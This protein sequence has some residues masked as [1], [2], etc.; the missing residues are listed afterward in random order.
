M[1]QIRTEIGGEIRYL[2]LNGNNTVDFELSFAE[3]QDLT[4]KNSVY[5][6]SFNLPGSK[7]NADIFN[8]FFDINA[9]MTDYDVRRKFNAQVL[10]NGYELLEGYI[11]LESVSVFPVGHEY[12]ITFYGLIGSLAS[13][14]G[15]KYLSA[16]DLSSLT[17]PYN[18]TVV[19]FGSFYDPDIVIP[20]GT[21]E[22]YQD[23]RVWWTLLSRGYEYDNL[24]TT[25]QTPEYLLTPVLDFSNGLEYGYMD[26]IGTPVRY[27]YFVPSIQIR[28]LYT[29]IV[30]QA[31]FGIK[32]D[33][34]DTAYFKRFYLPQTFF[35]SLYLGQSVEPNYRFSADT[36]TT[37][38]IT[39]TELPSTTTV[40]F[41]RIRNT[42]VLNDNF[43]ATSPTTYTFILT[44]NGFYNCRMTFDGRNSELTPETFDLTAYIDLFIHNIFPGADDTNTGTTV[45]AQT[46]DLKPGQAGSY[47][48]NIQIPRQQLPSP[49]FAI[50][51][52]LYGLGTFIIDNFDF[53]VYGGPRILEAPLDFSKEFPCCEVKQIDFIT[54]INRIFNL[55]VV[56]DPE[57]SNTLR[58]EPYIDW[59]GKGEI[60]DWT[61]KVDRNSTITI[62]PTT[63]IIN[64][65][66]NFNW[67]TD[68]DYGNEEFTKKQNRQFGYRLQQLD[69]D[70]ADKSV[71][72][73]SIFTTNV[74]Y[75]LNNYG[76]PNPNITLPYYHV[77]LEDDV[78]GNVL[79]QFNPFK[80]IPRLLYRGLNIPNASLGQG[81]TES[82]TTRFN[83]WYIEGTQM[84]VFPTVN[85]F[86]TY[87]FAVSGF[88]H[89]INYN[90]T[91]RFDP[92]ELDFSDYRDI[93]GVY[94]QEVMEDLISEESRIVT[95]KVYL[96]PEDIKTY[97]FSEKIFLDGNYYRINK[98]KYNLSE[99]GMADFEL[100]KF[101]KDYL[102]HPK[103]CFRLAPCDEEAG[104]LYTNTDLNATIYAYVGL[105]INISGYCY[106]IQEYTCSDDV[107]Y[108]QVDAGGWQENS[109]LPNIYTDCGCETLFTGVTVYQDP[110]PFESPTP[111]PSPTPTPTPSATPGASPTPRYYYYIMER[112]D[113]QVQL[114]VR[115]TSV[116]TAGQVYTINAGAGTFCYFVVSQ[117]NIP[118]S[119]DLISAYASCESCLGAIA[120]P[121]PTPTQTKTPTP[122]PTKTLT[123]TPSLTPSLTPGYVAEC[124]TYTIT[125][126]SDEI[127]GTYDAVL[128]SAGCD[129]APT[130][131]ELGFSQEVEI[132]AC[133]GSVSTLDLNV[134]IVSGSTCFPPASATP[135]PTSTPTQTPT[136]SVP[137]YTY[138]GRTT[139]DAADGPTACST[140]LT[141]R[142]YVGLKPLASLIVGD[143]IYDTYPSSPTNGGGQWVALKVGGAGQ[144][145]AFQIDTN[146]EILDTYTC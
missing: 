43:G 117:T 134:Q 146:G 29:Q 40:G 33:F 116:L 132:C 72:F 64:G 103:S 2:D 44:E 93:Y 58:V 126:T 81:T 28:E 102:G 113:A 120:S 10:Y 109:F 63:N 1:L 59:V 145:Y 11:R 127:P 39:W 119:F 62:R 87:P 101:T 88:S 26:Y 73:N 94:Y 112:C 71:D 83:N 13:N 70:F 57:L 35:D 49:Y 106:Q 4:K 41:D 129:S 36:P 78:E 104:V 50:D 37:K 122:T 138:L 99:A 86:N 48:F 137:T 23:G 47:N 6:K 8:Y 16:L 114:I 22:S 142:G 140:Y 110:A 80:T 105:N 46:L 38:G 125:N 135:Q 128:C 69:Q 77:T 20:T 42:T 67:K 89:Y 66:L 52:R 32:S 144:G 7:N 123:P 98:L 24:G 51:F 18:S 108:V 27:S 96:T 107:N 34:F 15:D 56:P 84:D 9:T 136:S 25:G 31:G 100:V 12:T 45:F 124:A 121:T 82:G 5:T 75:V 30:N 3:I 74:D 85:R 115:S 92:F 21:T 79:F 95:G 14:L 60:V 133:I 90:S 53:E 139:P 17:H 61:E 54:S 141:A 65:T 55:V 68:K 131:Y 91:D 97:D 111:P 19:P 76:N 118:S 130:T 143:F